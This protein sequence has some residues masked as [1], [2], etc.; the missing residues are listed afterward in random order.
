MP[1]SSQK[2]IKVEEARNV[3]GLKSFLQV[4]EPNSPEESP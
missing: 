4:E 2:S 1:A 3:A